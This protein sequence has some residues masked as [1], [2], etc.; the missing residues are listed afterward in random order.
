MARQCGKKRVD[1]VQVTGEEAGPGAVWRRIVKAYQESSLDEKEFC[2]SWGVGKCA[3]RWWVERLAIVDAARS[4]PQA[5]IKPATS[6]SA[7]MKRTGPMA[8]GRPTSRGEQ[9]WGPLVQELATSGLSQVEFARRRKVSLY[10]LRWWKWNLGRR[11]STPS[12]NSRAGSVDGSA[13][14]H[15]QAPPFLPVTVVAPSASDA[16]WSPPGLQA[17]DD[18]EDWAP[19]EVILPSRRRI[20]VRQDFDAVLLMRL[21]NTLERSS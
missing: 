1:S 20:A 4:C 15:P 19:L 11:S 12:S 7:A 21:V 2:Q 6:Q 18:A 9:K 8:T 17:P 5:S 14:R 3:L 13:L 10:S 16:G